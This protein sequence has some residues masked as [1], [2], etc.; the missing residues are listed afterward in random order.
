MLVVSRPFAFF[1]LDVESRLSL[2]PSL[3]EIVCWRF[4][5]GSRIPLWTMTR[6][7]DSGQ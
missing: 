3:P 4:F 2:A 7:F 6:V 5:Q 1:S